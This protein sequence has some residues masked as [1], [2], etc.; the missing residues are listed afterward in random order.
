MYP[1]P[2]AQANNGG[3]KYLTL[4]V[5]PN[6]IATNTTD[7]P[8]KPSVTEYISPKRKREIAHAVSITLPR[9]KRY[10]REIFIERARL[11]HNDNFDYSAIAEHHVKGCS[12]HI[13]LSCNICFHKWNPTVS[14][15]IEGKGCPSCNGHLRWT[16]DRF[17]KAAREIHGDKYDYSAITEAHISGQLS[18]VPITCKLCRFTW[19]PVIN[20]HINNRTKCPRCTRSIPWTLNSFIES[21]RK[22]HGDKY[23]YSEIIEKDI[24]SAHSH[25]PLSCNTCK[26][27][28]TPTISKHI[29]YESGCPRCAGRAPLSLPYF[30]AQML[31]IHGDDYDLSEVTEVDVKSCNSTI[32]VICR[33]CKLRWHPQI[34]SLI[35]NKSGCP[36]CKISKGER[37]CRTVLESL[38]IV[39][40]PQ[41]KI[42]SLPTRLFD[43]GFESDGIN[44]LLEYDGIQHFKLNVLFHDDD[45]DKFHEAQEV[46][47]L[48]TEIAVKEGYHVIHIDYTQ[49]N[50]AKYHIVRALNMKQPIYFSTPELYGHFE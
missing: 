2:I 35:Y 13:P 19:S 25:I 48:K 32:P 9:V 40:T 6:E 26:H 31:L 10:T 34:R 39:P 18:A 16:L 15:I 20:H 23:D 42:K 47:M 1:K 38:N 21:A 28:W 4:N 27:R 3:A 5:I 14:A 30:R 46:D 45:I 11:I 7:T 8:Y 41:V 36:S 50:N 33:S 37:A 43:F 12:S 44:W 24:K 49:L 22:I 17:V 29:S